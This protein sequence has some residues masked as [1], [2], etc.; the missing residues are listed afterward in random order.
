MYKWLL[1][2]VEQAQQI[3]KS[4]N[5]NLRFKFNSSAQQNEI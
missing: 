3:L 5:I 1:E 4:Q 2:K